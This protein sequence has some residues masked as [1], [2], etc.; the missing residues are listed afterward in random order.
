MRVSLFNSEK[1]KKFQ[2]HNR[3][4]DPEKVERERR[5]KRYSKKKGEA[6]FDKDEFRSELQHRWSLKRESKLPFNQ[7][8]SSTKRIILTFVVLIIVLALFYLLAMITYNLTK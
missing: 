4:Y 1:P 3:F 6:E 8:I 5:H 7:R 2:F